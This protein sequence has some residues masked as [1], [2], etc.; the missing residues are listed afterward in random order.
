MPMLTAA[1]FASTRMQGKDFTDGAH[2]RCR[3]HPVDFVCAGTLHKREKLQRVRQQKR[4][5]ALC[6][7][8][9]LPRQVKF[10][11]KTPTITRIEFTL[12]NR[13]LRRHGIVRPHEA[14]LLRKARLWD[15]VSFRKVDQSEG[16]ALPARIRKHWSRLGHG[17]PPDMPSSIVLK[18]LRSARL[19]PSRWLVRSS[20]EVLL[21]KMQRNMI[22]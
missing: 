13:F 15:H 17:L 16:D 9:E 8:S 14:F 4:D 7:G 21:R 11:E 22:W 6:R 12:R 5:D 18:A 2:V 3:R 20:R 1:A 19:D 10:Y